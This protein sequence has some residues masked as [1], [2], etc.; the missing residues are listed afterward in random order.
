[1]HNLRHGFGRD[2]ILFGDQKRKHLT[3]SKTDDNLVNVKSQT[4]NSSETAKGSFLT[5]KSKPECSVCGGPPLPGQRHCKVCHTEYMRTWRAA[6]KT[7]GEVN[8]HAAAAVVMAERWFTPVQVALGLQISRAK[9]IEM[10][11]R[12]S[13]V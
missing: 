3:T 2:H 4:V 8:G 13:V 7:K 6:R 10:L 11:D 5:K 12:K 9:V 1:M